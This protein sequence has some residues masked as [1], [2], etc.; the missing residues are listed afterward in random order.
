MSQS[1]NLL[2]QAIRDAVG[3]CNFVKAVLAINAA[4]A[5]T[6]KT[7]SALTYAI[8][9]VMYT[10]AALSAQS[11]AITHDALGN[12]VASG[13]PAYVQPANTTVFY[14]LSANAAGTI[15]VSQGLYAGQSAVVGTPGA[16]NFDAS[17]T[18][19]GTGAIP[20]EPAGYTTFGAIKIANTA[21][22][23]PATTALDAAGITATYYDLA[24]APPSL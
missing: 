6:V 13:I 8:A 24:L 20:E 16:F 3:N 1:K 22:F 19:T 9:G 17:K 10:K 14:L 18:I 12:P 15:A 23:T 21:A 11:I 4:S 7:T 2:A 5:A